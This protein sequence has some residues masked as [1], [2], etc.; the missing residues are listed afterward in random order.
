MKIF[1]SIYDW[2]LAWSE[3]PSGPTVLGIV[4]FMEASF[5]P[6]PPDVL[7]IP[8]AIGN[9][10]RAIWFALICSVCSI[11]GAIAGYL[12]GYFVWWDGLGQFSKFSSLFFEFI[13]GFSVE[14]FS[15]IQNKYEQWN[16]WIIFTAGFT[17]IPFKLFTI[18]AGAFKINFAAFLLASFVGRSARFFL[19]SLLIKKF[20]E[21]IK[22]FID[23]YFNLLAILV[24]I[25]LIGWFLIV[26]TFL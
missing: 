13:P 7:L 25:L 21:P 10:K 2:V 18:S 3:K 22:T 26:K 17:P 5:F 16:F 12:I 15:K 19:V 11:L 20:G 24:S 4:S 1:R 6:I 9:Q 14:S 23:S 8:L